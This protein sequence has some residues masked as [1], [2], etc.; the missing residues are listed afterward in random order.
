MYLYI[1]KFKGYYG[2]CWIVRLHG[3][4][5]PVPRGIIK[6][7]Y[8]GI[9]LVTG[10]RICCVHDPRSVQ[11][12][13][14]EALSWELKNKMVM[15]LE[16]KRQWRSCS[17]EESLE[18]TR[19]VVHTTNWLPG[20]FRNLHHDTSRADAASEVNRNR[21]FE[22]SALLVAPDFE[23]RGALAVEEPSGVPDVFSPGVL[24]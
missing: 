14:K 24:D 13:R 4:H 16:V 8:N 7:T 3:L 10:E 19:Q 2:V 6:S 1:H 5:C 11:R 17:H 21:I 15:Y 9:F 18:Q 12:E 23:G 22:C 20:G